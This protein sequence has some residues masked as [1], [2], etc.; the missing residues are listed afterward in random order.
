LL[1][2]IVA[3]QQQQQQPKEEEAENNVVVEKSKDNSENEVPSLATLA[4]PFVLTRMQL[5]QVS[6]ERGMGFTTIKT[7]LL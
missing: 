2:V 1:N 3:L 7:H 6:R 4:L 5:I